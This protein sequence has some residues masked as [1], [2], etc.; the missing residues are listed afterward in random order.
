LCAP[1][2]SVIDIDRARLPSAVEVSGWDGAQF[3]A[4]LRHEPSDPRF[5]AGLRQLV[6]VSFK[7]A[8]KR[9]TAYTDLLKAHREVVGRNVTDNLL[10]RHLRPLFVG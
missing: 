5:H 7:L 4:A 10:R 9:G 1:Y 3:A 8:A 2:A 6:H